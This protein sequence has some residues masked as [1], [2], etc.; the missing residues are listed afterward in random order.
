MTEGE[1]IQTWIV[2]KIR[3]NTYFSSNAC[4]TGTHIISFCVDAVLPE[5]YHLYHSSFFFFFF[6]RLK[7][8]F[9]CWGEPPFC[10]VLCLL[11]CNMKLCISL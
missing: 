1:K 8:T 4:V 5:S 6:S 10:S 7:S 11:L 2:L 9:S 3:R